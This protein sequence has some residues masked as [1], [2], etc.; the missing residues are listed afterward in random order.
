MI[1]P[2]SDFIKNIGPHRSKYELEH[3]TAHTR[4]KRVLSFVTR[5]QASLTIE[6]ALVLPSH[7]YFI[8]NIIRCTV[9]KDFIN[10]YLAQI[11]R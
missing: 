11:H 3:L 7:Q 4:K 2:F 8:I 9:T 5:K 10:K 1:M 6:T